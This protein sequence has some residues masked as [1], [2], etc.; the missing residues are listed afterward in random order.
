MQ[1]VWYISNYI[2]KR[3]KEIYREIYISAQ[4]KKKNKKH[5]T[6]DTAVQK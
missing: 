6:T 3:G 1:Q 5:K 2:I 4:G